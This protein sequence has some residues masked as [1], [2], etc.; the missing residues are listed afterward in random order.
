[1]LRRLADTDGAGRVDGTRTV[2]VYGSMTEDGILYKRARRARSA[3]PGC[4]GPRV[5]SP[6]E[7]WKGYSGFISADILRTKLPDPPRGP[8][9]RGPAAM[10]TAIKADG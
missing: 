3:V 7:G 9:T 8:T 2:L 1:M 10:V 4:A 6:A 5:T